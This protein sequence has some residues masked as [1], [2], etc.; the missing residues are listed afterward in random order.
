MLKTQ[1]FKMKV[2]DISEE[3]T[4][5]GEAEEIIQ[6][7]FD[8]ALEEIVTSLESEKMFVVGLQIMTSAEYI[9]AV[10]NYTDEDPRFKRQS[11][12]AIPQ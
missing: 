10:I 2:S 8:L 11:T 9:I 3:K 6:T 5:E 7:N 4:G 12:L 1:T